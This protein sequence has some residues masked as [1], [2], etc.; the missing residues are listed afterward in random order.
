MIRLFSTKPVPVKIKAGPFKGAK[1]FLNPANSKRKILGLY[2]HV[3]NRWIT[4]KIKEKEFVMDVGANTGYDTY[5]FA[6]LL[7]SNGSNNPVVLAFEPEKYT[8]LTTPKGW[9][10]YNGCRIEIIEK[11]IG[12]QTDYNRIALDDAYVEYIGE[13]GSSG[14]VKID[15]EGAECD[16]LAGANRMLKNPGIDWLIE[17]H[18]KEL[19]PEVAGYFVKENRPFLIKDLAPLPIIGAEKRFLYTSWLMTI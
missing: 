12:K 1:V 6:H 13:I 9:E 4:E 3:L 7:L 14:L 17:I 8:E 2:E 11:Y 16:A 18:G 15:I 10:E 5:G 19:I